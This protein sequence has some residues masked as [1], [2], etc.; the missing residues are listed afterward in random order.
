MKLRQ[1]API[2]GLVA[3]VFTVSACGGYFTTNAGGTRPA[4]EDKPAATATKTPAAKP[5]S[6]PAASRA[7]VVRATQK[8]GWTPYMQ[9]SE[10][11]T[12]Y[13]SNKDSNQPATSNCVGQCAEKFVP[14]PADGGTVVEGIDQSMIG[15]LDRPDGTSQLTIKD[16]PAYTY[17]G[18]TKPGAMG[19]QGKENNW[20]AMA[21]DGSKALT[22]AEAQKEK[23]AGTVVT[24][25][26]L[27]GFTSTVLVSGKGRTM[28][29]F[30]QDTP[31]DGTSACEGDADCNQKWPPVLADGGLDVVE[32]CVD[33]DL[34]GTITRKD[35]TKQV[36]VNGSPVYYYFQDQAPGD[37]K[38]HGV[39]GVWFAAG[40]DGQRAQKVGEKDP[41]AAG[42]DDGGDGGSDD[43]GYDY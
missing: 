20:Y 17:K 5:T 27:A 1:I 7:L 18:D 6:T 35:G 14:V 42:N 29:F 8:A 31:N 38:G 39:G 28:Y 3:G 16:W 9:T 26:K 32:D 34:V 13:R 24:D 21:P 23:P 19:A 22:Q 33:P 40:G 43:G 11:K 25:T 41:N 15:S 37:A 36:T 30:A 4:A 12:L 2:A 10:G